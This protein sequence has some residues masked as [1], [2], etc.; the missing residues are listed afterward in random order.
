MPHIN[1]RFTDSLKF[2]CSISVKSIVA[3]MSQMRDATRKFAIAT[4]RRSFATNFGS[5][6]KCYL[7]ICDLF[8]DLLS[9][10]DNTCTCES[11][12]SVVKFVALRLQS[13]RWMWR[14]SSLM[15]TWCMAQGAPERCTR[16]FSF[17][18]MLAIGAV[19]KE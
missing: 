4:T 9:I 19:R 13:D 15:H 11:S 17:G 2:P 12:C 10:Y 1:R 6:V 5:T 14:V 3:V 8:F 18:R 16:T 7:R